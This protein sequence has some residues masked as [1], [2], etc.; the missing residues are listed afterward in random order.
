MKIINIFYL[1]IL[2]FITFIINISLLNGTE[3]NCSSQKSNIVCDYKIE[4]NS[5]NA[6]NLG[7]YNIAISLNKIKQINGV[8]NGEMYINSG[9]C[10]TKLQNVLKENIQIAQAH[11]NHGYNFP[12]FL[13]REIIEADF[14]V[15]ILIKNCID[16]CGELISLK[17]NLSPIMKMQ[18]R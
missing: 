4:V 8:F 16:S 18:R 6:S 10:G 9:K 1:T 15:K 14:C 2:L 3:L 11:D 12:L 7:T 17:A 5:E 13:H